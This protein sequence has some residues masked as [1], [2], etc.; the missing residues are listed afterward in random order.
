MKRTRF[1]NIICLILCASIL[2]ACPA[3]AK[4]L[5]NAKPFKKF[6]VGTM[7][8]KKVT[9]EGLIL[10]DSYWDG[11]PDLFLSECKVTGTAGVGS[12]IRYKLKKGYTVKMYLYYRTGGKLKKQRLKS[13]SKLKSWTIGDSFIKMLVKKGKY[14][15]Y[16]VIY[17]DFPDGE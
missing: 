14:K 3:E 5:W 17:N 12:R 16:L 11:V 9:N 13:G 1:A 7:N 8:L 2:F 6:S 15:S 4:I 10:T